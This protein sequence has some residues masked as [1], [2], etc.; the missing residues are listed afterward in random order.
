MQLHVIDLNQF[1]VPNALSPSA[2][3]LEAAKASESKYFAQPCII[4]LHRFP[5]GI[6]H[7]TVAIAL[8]NP[9]NNH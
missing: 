5:A 9:I 7:L 3:N 4:P 8:A 1:Q 6:L 2:E